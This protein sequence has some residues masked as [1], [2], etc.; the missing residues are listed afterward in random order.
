MK[1]ALKSLL[2]KYILLTITITGK[3]DNKISSI[4]SSIHT[5]WYSKIEQCHLSSS[6]TRT[7]VTLLIVWVQ[8][9]P[10]EFDRTNENKKEY[11]YCINFSKHSVPSSIK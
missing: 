2:L 6:T 8:I 3:L 4:F 11:L 1:I 9:E 5:R 7:S 10:Y